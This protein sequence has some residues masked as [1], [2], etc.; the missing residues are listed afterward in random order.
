[1]CLNLSMKLARGVGL[2]SVCSAVGDCRKCWRLAI[3]IHHARAGTRFC[4]TVPP[5]GPLVAST[6]AGY[7]SLVGPVHAHEP[8]SVSPAAPLGAFNLSPFQSGDAGSTPVPISQAD[9]QLARTP[10][11]RVA[12]ACV[13]IVDD[14]EANR[15]FAAYALAKLGCIV[16][17]VGDGDE[18]IGAVTAAAASGSPF[19]VV[20]MDLVMVCARAAPYPLQCVLV[21]VCGH[22]LSAASHVP[23]P[24]T[25]EWG[26]C[27]RCTARGG[28]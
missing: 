27:A 28:V 23:A 20:L 10:E 7:R 16:T 11:R 3:A 18:V 4:L 24:E 26:H 25:H 21:V 5:A 13:L 17:A 2:A 8:R 22:P 6:P 1:M 15:R 14:S 9:L 12:G 19:D